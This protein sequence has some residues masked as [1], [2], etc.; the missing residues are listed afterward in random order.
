MKSNKIILGTVQFGLDYGINNNHGKPN[1]N[2]VNKIL[3]KAQ[4]AGI[5]TL[6]TA[7]AY[8]NAHEVIGAFHEK[9][10]TNKFQINTKLYE[11]TLE[12][13]DS[14]VG[15]FLDQL[16]VKQLH[17]IS[18]HSFESY[19]KNLNIL[20]RLN[21]YREKGLIQNIGVSV[22]T[23]EQLSIVLKDPSLDII[24]LP[25]NVFDNINVRGEFLRLAKSLGKTIHTRS[26]FLQGLF[27]T[28]R[29]NESKV[30]IAL[31]EELAL[32]RNISKE[33]GYS[34]GEIALNYS[35]QEDLIDNIILGVDNVEQLVSNLEYAKSDLSIEVIEKL[36]K[37]NIENANLLNPSLWN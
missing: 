13:I 36:N 26:A 16:N 14:R 5:N 22:Y 29:G 35:L 15:F 12:T 2:Q 33:S 18:F 4:D 28:E 23:N 27:F 11:P 6:D 30:A 8:G 19:S 3:L 31:R 24:Q 37:I 21:S 34:I 10:P 17:A 1:Q 32:L 9:Y 7:E 20:K 25:Y